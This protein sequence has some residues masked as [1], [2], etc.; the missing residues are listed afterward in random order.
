MYRPKINPAARRHRSIAV[1]REQDLVDL[2]HTRSV[3]DDKPELIALASGETSL[4]FLQRSYRS[5]K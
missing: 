2:Q 5:A 4:N 3:E 1:I